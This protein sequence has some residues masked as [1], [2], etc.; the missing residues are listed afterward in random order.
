MVKSAFKQSQ[1]IDWAFKTSFLYLGGYSET[2]R[3]SP[4][5]FKDQIDNVIA[6]L[7]EVKP[8]H[9]KI[10]EYV[11]RLSYGP[12]VADLAMTD[13][14]KP[15]YPD[16][17]ANKVLDPNNLAD[18]K[19][20]SLQ[21]PWKDWY[22]N[23][24]KPVADLED[25]DLNWNGV[26]KLKVKVKFDRI[27]CGTVNGWDTTPWDPALMVYS[28][29][30]GETQS[31]SSLNALYR[32]QNTQGDPLYYRDQVVETIEDRNYLVRKGIVTEDRPGTIV[33]VLASGE[34]FMWSGQEWFAFESIGWDK[35]PDMGAVSRTEAAYRPLPGMTR[36]DDPGLIAGCEFDGTVISSNFVQDEWD[37]FEWDSTGYSQGLREHV[38]VDLDT[39]EGNTTAQ[40]ESDPTNI[41]ISGNEFAQPNR[42]S[43]RP[44][45][46]VQ[47]RG[48]ESIVIN[49][50]QNGTPYQ[51]SFMNAMQVW[52]DTKLEAN[53]MTFSA[54]DQILKTLT[55]NVSGW[56]EDA[57]GFT[58]L[59]DPQNPST[60]FIRD[61]ML[62]KGYRSASNVNMTT[63]GT[64]TFKLRD[65]ADVDG[66]PAGLMGNGVKVAVVNTQDPSKRAIGVV[67]NTRGN[68][69]TWNGSIS[70]TFTDG[71]VDLGSGKSW[72]IIPVDM[73]NEPGIVWIDNARFTYTEVQRNGNL[74]T[75]KNA[76]LSASSLGCLEI[77]EDNSL[78][79]KSTNTVLDGSKHRQN[80]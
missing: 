13:F 50:K 60:G 65:L 23:Y 57:N 26:R 72:N 27:A 79:L 66:I 4:V 5:A 74:V 1:V 28:Q 32:S 51:K 46:L 73:F 39:I 63:A 22:E 7:E 78:T 30:G 44:H 47:I 76:R 52:Q 11:R 40:D 68:E 70:V 45:E 48:L 21:R 14:D 53:G 59:H 69:K 33:T 80:T 75:L 10:R 34:H 36:A 16:G 62:S 71:F 67:S 41:K 77:A 38:G 55:V 9:V 2:L 56:T 37:I 20:L 29:I 64:K 3:Q 19:I 12:D 31:L 35:G 24:Q 18:Q 58:P 6:Y 61:I 25:W 49:V 42:D 43:G 54:W 17:Q 8:Y 15:V